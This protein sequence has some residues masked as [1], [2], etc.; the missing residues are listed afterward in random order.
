LAAASSVSR[1]M[2]VCYESQQQPLA[3]VVVKLAS[4]LATN[5]D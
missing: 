2:I 4:L 5:A 1:R 3:E